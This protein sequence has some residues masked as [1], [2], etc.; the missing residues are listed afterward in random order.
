MLYNKDF[1]VYEVKFEHQHIN[2]YHSYVENPL[3]K[4]YFFMK[5]STVI[6]LKIMI[7]IKNNDIDIVH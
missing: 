7:Q 5:I 2:V 4:I 3:F 1:Y 6:I